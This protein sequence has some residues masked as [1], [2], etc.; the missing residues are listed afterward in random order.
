MTGCEAA[1]QRI[2]PPRWLTADRAAVVCIAT[3]VIVANIPWLTGVT[4]AN[5]M[6]ADSGLTAS[7]HGVLGGLPDLDRNAGFV[8]QA[9][10][11]RAALDLM[12]LH[13]PWWDPYEGTG[14]PLAGE[15]QSAALFPPTLLTR[16]ANGQLLEHILLEMTA[17][18]CTFLLLRRLGLAMVA[19]T[20][21]GVAFALNGTFAW[22]GHAPVNAVP[23]LPSLLLGVEL[24]LDAARGGRRGGWWLIAVS[25][26]L[27]IYAGFPEVAYLDALLA[28]LWA[29]CRLSE[30]PARVRVRL[31]G[32]VIAGVGAGTLLCAPLLIAFSDYLSHAFVSLHN[33]AA[34]SSLRVQHAALAQL[35]FPYVYGPLED[36]RAGF[37]SL[38]NWALLGGYLTTALI[39]LAALGLCAPGRTRLRV[40][41]AV[42]ITFALAGIYGVPPLLGHVI[43]VIPGMSHVEFVRYIWPSLELAAVIL[44]AFGLDA[45]E[46]KRLGIRRAAIGVGAAVIAVGAVLLPSGSVRVG[47]YFSESLMWGSIVGAA[48]AIVALGWR[49]RAGAVALAVLVV[50]DAV[51]MFA[52]PQLSA[53]RS[54]TIDTRT[55]AYLERH[56][57]EGRFFTLGP[58]APNYGAYYGIASV[59]ATDVPVP[60]SF[61]HF[62]RTR[63]DPG[64]D[65]TT[66]SGVDNPFRPSSL[67]SVPQ[68]LAI[69][70]ASYRAAAVAYVLTAPGATLPDEGSS[71]RR[72]FEGAS[73]WIYR[74]TAARPFF[75]PLGGRCVVSSSTWSA[76]RLRC[77]AAT[78]LIRRETYMPG[79][80]AS[81]DGHA[82]RVRQADGLFQAVSVPGGVHDVTFAFAPPEITLGLVAFAVGVG[83]LLLPPLARRRHPGTGPI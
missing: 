35:A 44:A 40:L 15:M 32:K 11:H 24:A 75:D 1:R 17:G 72:V 56:L 64:E 76:A 74:L 79:W 52:V 16:L 58:L 19:S 22:F 41:L 80:T 2:A 38:Y 7:A 9:L 26:A 43:G 12:H 68:A 65:G 78:T 71:F 27:S 23:F 28:G 57:G 70:L 37:Y 81:V 20:A 31:I 60:T 5:P 8:S 34:P 42:W 14:A 83:W 13:L 39:L 54:G 45:V 6:I 4:H 69:H 82:A 47:S 36:P 59:N 67:P 30:L 62:V 18:I 10:G 50:L 25:G 3:L 61:E 51:V 63:L 66:F 21:A 55:V 33:S 29:L 48:A 77:A 49:R 46:T 53:P 73:A